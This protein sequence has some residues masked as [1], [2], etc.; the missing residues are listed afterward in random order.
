[1]APARAGLVLPPPTE[2][3]PRSPGDTGARGPPE[4]REG[5]P[6]RGAPPGRRTGGAPGGGRRG[7]VGDDGDDGA[8]GR[9]G[10]RGGGGA[11]RGRRRRGRGGPRRRGPDRSWAATG[12]G[13]TG[14]DPTGER[15]GAETG[16]GTREQ[17]YSPPGAPRGGKGREIS[18]F[19]RRHK[20]LDKTRRSGGER[21]PGETGGTLGMFPPLWPRDGRMGR[22]SGGGGRAAKGGRNGEEGERGPP[23]AGERQGP[24]GPGP[25]PWGARGGP[26]ERRGRGGPS[27]PR[28][29]ERIF[30]VFLKNPF[31]FC[32]FPFPKIFFFVLKIQ[33]KFGAPFDKENLKKI[34]RPHLNFSM[35]LIFPIFFNF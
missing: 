35:I 23:P 25:P 32:F 26:G 11:R 13:D 1:M 29:G 2:A 17:I 7:A 24:R 34:L 18:P 14:A 16:E 5:K 4:R 31:N 28:R 6:G 22:I 21:G 19:L 20:P 10:R 15:T 9:A 27:P 12:E 33:V 8:R 30:W 3:A